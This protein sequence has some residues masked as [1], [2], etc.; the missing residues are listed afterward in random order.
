MTRARKVIIAVAAIVVGLA[1]TAYWLG[2]RG[3]VPDKK[4]PIATCRTTRLAPEVEAIVRN[5]LMARTREDWGPDY[6]ALEDVIK[7]SEPAASCGSGL[8]PVPYHYSRGVLPGV[9]RV[10]NN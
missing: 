1:A 4:A 9:S 8:W 3:P 10:A 7:S 5:V 6:A 2:H